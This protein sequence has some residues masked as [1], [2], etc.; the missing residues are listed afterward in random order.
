MWNQLVNY[1]QHMLNK[2]KLIKIFERKKR[3]IVSAC[4]CTLNSAYYLK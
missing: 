1:S 3:N 4:K 2:H